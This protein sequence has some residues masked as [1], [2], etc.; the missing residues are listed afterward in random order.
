MLDNTISVQNVYIDILSYK[1]D[2]NIVFYPHIQ[3]MLHCIDEA[4]IGR[5]SPKGCL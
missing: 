4:Q 3:D 1:L 2:N 5:N